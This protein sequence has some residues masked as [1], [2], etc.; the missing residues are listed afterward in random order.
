MRTAGKV[1]DAGFWTYWSHARFFRRLPSVKTEG[2]EEERKSCRTLKPRATANSQAI[3]R[4]PRA[5]REVVDFAGRKREKADEERAS[6]RSHKAAKEKPYPR[7]RINIPRQTWQIDQICIS[8]GALVGV[9][10]DGLS[11]LS[12]FLPPAYSPSFP[13][14]LF[15]ES[16]PPPP[17]APFSNVVFFL[18]LKILLRL[19]SIYAHNRNFLVLHE[20]FQICVCWEFN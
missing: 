20:F 19:S 14:A 7:T 17:L 5:V 13:S 4:S 8:P 12:T 16:V 11:L 10:F 2:E 1:S 9:N 15:R 3:L 6:E 18:S